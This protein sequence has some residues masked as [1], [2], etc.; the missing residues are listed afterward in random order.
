MTVQA[1]FA[2]CLQHL[3]ESQHAAKR[4]A[5]KK[6]H[7]EQ[8]K[9]GA[10]YKVGGVEVEQSGLPPHGRRHTRDAR[11][12]IGLGAPVERGCR[13]TDRPEVGV[14]RAGNEG[15]KSKLPLGRRHRGALRSKLPRPLHEEVAQTALRRNEKCGDRSKSR[16]TSPKLGN[17]AQA[18]ARVAAVCGLM[19]IGGSTVRQSRRLV[20][21]RVAW[22]HLRS[23]MPTC[24]P[25]R[26]P[27]RPFQASA[28]TGPHQVGRSG[29]R[30][31]LGPVWRVA[32][33]RWP[34]GRSSS[35]SSLASAEH[36]ADAP[37]RWKARQLPP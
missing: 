16:M 11:Q 31:G 22:T 4:G 25:S 19:G 23:S 34:G 5:G 35:R 24:P 3:G 32:S 9:P 27:T 20:G 8:C 28:R 36:H 6:A 1:R 17:F 37:P 2:A 26:T 15:A 33:P 30:G 29:R 7:P 21:R 14:W 12:P 13:R 18:G 10:Q